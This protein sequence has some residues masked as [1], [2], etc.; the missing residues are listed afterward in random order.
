MVTKRLHDVRHEK[1]DLKVF[2]IVLPKEGWARVAVPNLLLVWHRLSVLEFWVFWLH[3]SYSLKV[4]V[5][6]KEGTHLSLGVTVTKT[7]RSVFSGRA[8]HGF[9]P[10]GY[11]YTLLYGPF[12]EMPF[13]ASGVGGLFDPPILIL[14]MMLQGTCSR[15]LIITLSPIL[16]N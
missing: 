4:G 15:S 9:S 3:R 5:I 7:L 6:P 8:S 13:C 1:S 12:C 16:K 14:L 10:P 11:M 2:V